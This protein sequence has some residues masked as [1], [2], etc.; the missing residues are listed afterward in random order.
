[1]QFLNIKSL[2]V[3][4]LISLMMP[5]MAQSPTEETSK[6]HFVPPPVPD[7]GSPRGRSRGGASRNDACQVTDQPLT[8]LVPL[9]KSVWGLTLSEHPTLLF[10]VPYALTPD[11]PMEFVLQDE[12]QNTLYQAYLNTSLT[13][14]GVVKLT[15]P[16][17]ITPLEIDKMYHW[18]FLVYC[19]RVEPVFVEGWVKRIAPNRDLSVRLKKAVPEEKIALMAANGIWYDA[20]SHLAELRLTHPQDASL[21]VDW[22]NLLES[23]GLD[24]I[25]SEPLLECCSLS[26]N[27]N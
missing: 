5:A 12:E 24:A 11:S 19:N 27:E 14:P 4:L 22:E 25:A 2:A 13:S 3:W 10:Y 1:M 7:R 9:S 23:V 21:I 18:Y 26:D 8:A 6:I 15:M 16:D 17:G 20:L